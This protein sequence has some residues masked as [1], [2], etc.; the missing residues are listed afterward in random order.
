MKS[1]K[2]KMNIYLTPEQARAPEVPK[3]RLFTEDD[4]VKKPNIPVE[5]GPRRPVNAKQ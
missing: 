3:Y 1:A 2:V 5:D 4:H